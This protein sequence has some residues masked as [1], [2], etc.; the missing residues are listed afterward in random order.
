MPPKLPSRKLTIPNLP[1][2]AL[3]LIAR[4]QGIETGPQFSGPTADVA[5]AA[6][7]LHTTPRSIYHR[8]SRGQMPRPLPGR[9]LVWL[10]Q[11][12]LEKDIAARPSST[13]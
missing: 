7:I 3:E 2:H 1:V 8:H 11:D 13:R 10:I 12:L 5:G 6:K 9:R 4:M